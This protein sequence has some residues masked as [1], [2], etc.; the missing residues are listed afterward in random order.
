MQVQ[1]TYTSPSG[2]KYLQVITDFRILSENQAE[3]M[4]DMNF[5]LFAASNLQKISALI[6][7]ESFEAADTEIKSYQRIVEEVFSKK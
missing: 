1:L 4:K 2:D 7:E 3:I 5:G 6:K